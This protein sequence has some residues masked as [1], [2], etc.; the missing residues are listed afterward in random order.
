[1]TGLTVVWSPTVLVAGRGLSVRRCPVRN[2]SGTGDFFMSFQANVQVLGPT[3][4]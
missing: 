2:P 4:S 3:L 1:M